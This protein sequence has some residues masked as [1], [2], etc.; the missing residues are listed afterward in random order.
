MLNSRWLE[1]FTELCETRHFTRTA[2]RLAMT[3]PGV[4]QQLRKLEQQVGK[5]LI[6]RDG[7]SFTL[8]PAGEEI[9]ALGRARRREERDLRERI[10]IDDPD[11][12]EI[13][14]A[15]SGSFAMLLYPHLL[16]LMKAS[17]RLTVRVEAAPES[18]IMSG[19]LEG[20]F[21]FAISGR[22]PDHFHI[23]CEHL[24]REELCLVVPAVSRPERICFEDLEARG[25]IAHPD[26]FRYADDL[27][28]ANFPAQYTGP[29]RLR[30]R[31]YV[32]QISLIPT[33]VAHGLGYTL[34]P[35]SGVDAFP[36]RGRLHVAQLPEIR[37]HDLWM[38]LR[39]G[40]QVPARAERL[41]ELVR[42]V[43]GT[44]ATG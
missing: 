32:N 6:S 20:D 44:L 37:Q 2:E 17:P 10:S 35:R 9:Y 23:A 28:G 14:I 16:P 24:A 4:S 42:S 8:T 25:F 34:L 30:V 19:V 5:P 39:R 22:K 21:D 12:G 29:D 27:L 36:D 40:R 41:L 1:T 7:K 38:L 18:R 15:C 11:A 26:G 31:A 33:P 3:Q 43:A 13:V